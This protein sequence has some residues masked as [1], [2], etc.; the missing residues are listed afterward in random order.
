MLSDK[1]KN[2]VPSMEKFVKMSEVDGMERGFTFRANGDAKMEEICETGS[3]CQIEIKDITKREGTKT[4]L[5]HTHP[6]VTMKTRKTHAIG[7]TFSCSDILAQSDNNIDYSCVGTKDE[8]VCSTLKTKVSILEKIELIEC[9]NLHH[10]MNRFS[11]GD[12]GYKG[13]EDNNR[14]LRILDRLERELDTDLQHYMNFETIKKFK[15]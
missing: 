11:I 9:M 5:F 12:K 4:G 1:L 7:G 6:T 15:I 2:L 8:I 3:A 13:S 14:D 10:R